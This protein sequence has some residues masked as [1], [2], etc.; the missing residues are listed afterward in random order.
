MAER[1][2][3]AAINPRSGGNKGQAVLAQLTALIGAEQVFDL[4]TEMRGPGALAA[5]LQ[6]HNVSMAWNLDYNNPLWQNGTGGS[7]GV[8][9][10]EP[11]AVAAFARFAVATVH[12]FH[13]RG[14]K[15]GLY[16]EPNGHGY[17]PDPHAYV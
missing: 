8:A 2:V 7:Q 14:I 17:G 6:Q 13:G 3:V 16:N 4:T 10:T 9:V 15:W 1:R 12:R 11:E 5:Q